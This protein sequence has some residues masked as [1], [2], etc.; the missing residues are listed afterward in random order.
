MANGNSVF[1]EIRE[2]HLKVKN[3]KGMKAFILHLFHYYKWYALTG[4]AVLIIVIS[5]IYDAVTQKDIVLQAVL[6]NA[7]PNVGNEEFMADYEKT[8]TINPKKE[9]TSLISDF[10]INVDD[11]TIFEAEN[12][13]KLLVLCAS[14]AVDVCV[15]DESYLMQMAQG[16][17]YMDLSTV[18]TKEQ[19]EKYSDRLVWHDYPDDD[20]DAEE[21]IALEITDAAKIVSTQSYPNTK[22][23]F[24]I[25]FNAP[26]VDNSL[27]FLDYLETP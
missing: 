13:Q 25:M 10:Y 26:N 2:Q 12:I 9:E 8:I 16:G 17:Y 18:F 27:A 7:F 15:V 1:D 22:C 20:K 14:G 3:E 6:V 11:P 19:M 21:A 24:A 5:M 4:L 23:Y